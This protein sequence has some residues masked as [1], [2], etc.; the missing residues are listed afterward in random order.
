MKTQSAQIRS[1]WQ[2][3][4]DDIDLPF[5]PE[6]QRQ[7][8]VANRFRRD[9]EDQPLRRP[10]RQL[11][12][13]MQLHRSCPQALRPRVVRL[14]GVRDRDRVLALRVQ[15]IVN[16]LNLPLIPRYR[17]RPLVPL[18]LMRAER[19]HLI[20]ANV[21]LPLPHPAVVI[22]LQMPPRRHRLQLPF[23]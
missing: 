16:R 3:R 5:E 15:P 8:P 10:L 23:R 2:T 21:R 9:P 7:L 22:R 6:L 14:V 13:P 17:P 11:V 1:P 12:Q 20:P 4:L 18:H 19:V